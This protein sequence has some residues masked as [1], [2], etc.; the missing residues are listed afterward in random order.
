MGEGSPELQLWGE[1]T[2]KANWSR[3][4]M[5]DH[6]RVILEGEGSRVTAEAVEPDPGWRNIWI[7]LGRLC[8]RQAAGKV[9]NAPV[10]T[11]ERA[12]LLAVA[13]WKPQRMQT[14][15]N[16]FSSVSSIVCPMSILIWS[17]LITVAVAAKL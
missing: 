1:I 6:L 7:E 14:H 13:P 5:R 15:S 12:D 9:A 4:H 10:I 2:A 16:D 17:W 3:A 11:Q 8:K